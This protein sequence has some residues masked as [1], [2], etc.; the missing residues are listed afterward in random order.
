[1]I[2]HQHIHRSERQYCCDVCNKA[3]PKEHS[4]ENHKSIHSVEFSY[5]H[6]CNETFIVKRDILRLSMHRQS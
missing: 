5:C 1:M 6:V 3:F 2:R 4:L